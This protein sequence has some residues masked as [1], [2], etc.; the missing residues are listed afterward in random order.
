MYNNGWEYKWQWTKTFENSREEILSMSFTPKVDQ[1]IFDVY[2]IGRHIGIFQQ[3]TG[4]IPQHAISLLQFKTLSW[5]WSNELWKGY[6]SNFKIPF[7][8]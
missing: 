8:R 3:N 5:K 2:R 7:N 6:I 4:G 1:K